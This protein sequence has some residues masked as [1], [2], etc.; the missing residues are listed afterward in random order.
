MEAPCAEGKVVELCMDRR[1]TQLEHTFLDES[2]VRDDTPRSPHIRTL[3]SYVV[4]TY[5]CC[6]FF[7]SFYYDRGQPLSGPHLY[8]FEGKTFSWVTTHTIQ[9]CYFGDPV[10]SI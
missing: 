9:I 1:G 7:S 10:I 2:R 4:L 6:V 8:L 3:V 5:M